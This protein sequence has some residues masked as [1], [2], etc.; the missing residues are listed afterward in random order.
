[1]GSLAS[2][3]AAW[4]IALVVGVVYGAAGSFAHAA[5]IGPAP[6]GLLLGVIGAG[7][8]LIAVRLLTGDRW[9][10]LAAALGVM[11]ITYV[12]AQPSTGGSVLF[13]VAHETLALIWMGAVPLV[14]AVVVAWP[15]APR[16]AVEAN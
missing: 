16:R 4:A 13:T 9:A 11:V 10:T 14:A 1:M 3:I 8:L 15:R 12:F 5:F 6:I 7:A 2:R